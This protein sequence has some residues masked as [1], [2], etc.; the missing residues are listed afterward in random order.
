MPV[1]CVYLAMALK[2]Q[3]KEVYPTGP[4]SRV[5]KRKGIMA[6]RTTLSCIQ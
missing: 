3:R 4:V 2:G 1:L 5:I 6:V